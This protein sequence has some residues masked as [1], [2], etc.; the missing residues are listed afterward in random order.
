M[1][2]SSKNIGMIRNRKTD[3]AYLADT[4]LLINC[5]RF[6]SIISQTPENIDTADI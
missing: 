2:N 4:E 6:D 1:K 5:G 3:T